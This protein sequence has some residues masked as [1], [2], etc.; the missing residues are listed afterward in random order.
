M[1][2][3]GKMDHD[4]FFKW[5]NPEGL[6][7]DQ[8]YRRER[9][10]AEC[11]EV[12]EE[13]WDYFLGILPPMHFSRSGFAISEATSADLRLAFFRISNRNFAAYVSDYDKARN[14]ASPAQSDPALTP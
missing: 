5:L 13:T 1:Q 11:V 8:Q 14:M 7:I 9:L 6:T 10:L 4:Q 3:A 12:S 2:Y